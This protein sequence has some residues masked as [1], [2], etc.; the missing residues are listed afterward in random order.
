MKSI[1]LLAAAILMVPA[2]VTAQHAHS[3][4]AD[5][6]IDAS[7]SMPAEEVAQLLAGE[8]MGLAMPAELNGYPGPR[9]VI[10]LAGP[11][12]L[13]NR[14]MRQ[15]ALIRAQMSDA[16]VA[17]GED[18]LDAEAELT[19]LFRSGEATSPEV[20]RMTARIGALQGELRAIHLSAHL[21]MRS[22]LT[23]EQIAEYNRHR[24][25]ATP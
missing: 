24:G 11:L 12:A 13:S 18:I 6:T 15:V 5:M 3:P 8:G 17:K 7:V 2:H 14:Q 9:H 21:L 1:A 23:P 16:A 19:A 22:L 4:Y 10:D 25:Y 20:E